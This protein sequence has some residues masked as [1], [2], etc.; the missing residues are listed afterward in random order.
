[1]FIGAYYG[2]Q[3]SDRYKNLSRASMYMPNLISGRIVYIHITML[4][5]GSSDILYDLY[6]R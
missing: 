4:I 1:M 2:L 5:S 6:R 3:T